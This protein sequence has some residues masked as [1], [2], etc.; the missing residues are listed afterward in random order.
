MNNR[1]QNF[2]YHPIILMRTIQLLLIVFVCF[3]TACDKSQEKVITLPFVADDLEIMLWAESPMLYNPTN[4]DVDSRGRVWITEAV[5]YRNYNN[6]SATHLHHR[7]GD[8]VL[9]LE[10]TDQDGR[11]DKSKVFVQDKDLVSPLGIAVIGNKVY[12][13]CSPNLIVYTDE[14]HDDIPDKK[15]ILL[16]G[17]G[18]KDHD[19]S[20]HAIVGGPDGRLYFNCGNA[21]PHHVTD[22]AGWN[23]RSGSVYTGGSPYN[24]SNSPQQSDD[25]KV[26]IGGLALRMNPDGTGLSIMAHNF[27]NSYEIAVDSR[28]DIWQND[29]DDQVVACR[30]TWVMEGGNAGFFSN[31]GTRY[32]QADQRPGQD[33]FAAHWHQEDPGVM[34][35]GDRSGAGAPTGIVVY[36]GNALGEKYNGMLLSADAGRNVVFAYHPHI[37]RS[38]YNLNKRINF[39]TSLAEDNTGYV[40]DD[41]L[42]NSDSTKWFRPSDVAV[43]I[44]GAIFVADWYDPVVGGHQMEDSAGFGR[45]YRIVPKGKKLKM[46]DL[47]LSSTEG[48][49]EALLNPAVNVRHE[50]FMQ[51]SKKGDAIVPKLMPLL[52]EDNEFIRSRAIWLLAATGPNGKNEVQ[53]LLHDPDP[54]VRRVAFRALRANSDSILDYGNDIANDSSAFVR[55]ELIAAIMNEPYETVKPLLTKLMSKFDAD[56]RWYL[57][58]LGAAVSGHESDFMTEVEKYWNKDNQSPAH[59]GKEME[60]LAWRLHPKNYAA[61]FK[62]RALSK[63]LDRKQ[64]ERAITALGFINDRDAVKAMLSLAAGGDEAVREIASYWI[65]FRQSNDWFALADWTRLNINPEEQRKISVMKVK[66]SKIMDDVLPENEKKWNLSDMAR[67][68]TG[69]RMV[70]GAI[71]EGNFPPRLLDEAKD[72]LLKNE[73]EQ[74]KLQ[75][76]SL[77]T[78]SLSNSTAY[79]FENIRNL[80]SSVVKGKQ[81]F[82][83]YCAACH[84]VGTAGKNI[85][86]ELTGIGGKYDRERLIQAITDPSA[87]IVFGYETWTINTSNGMSYYGFI[88]GE[89]SDAV[90]VKDLS[91]TK[92]TIPLKNIKSRKKTEKS[93]MPDATAFGLDEQ[94]LADLSAYL[95]TLQ[96]Q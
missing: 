24:T 65:G 30:T 89:G 16:T 81:L 66:L 58:S 60:A 45:I 67:D 83:Q 82:Q 70:L 63:D 29:N 51:L 64:R 47:D 78:D 35:A 17:F 19:H 77:F 54:S 37:E 18:G 15:E 88:L 96:N 14:N 32:W 52:R 34:P 31:D 2:N 94:G 90:I 42:Q 41:S 39:L 21:G 44:D 74:I 7:A 6:D 68:E 50:A 56:D 79:S 57:E 84:R 80:K 69:A 5:N 72:L 13:S 43:G 92:H 33:V 20:L 28:G 73:N 27:R 55:R 9:I 46:P 38:G 23:L 26:W 85:G 93:I 4:M 11:A 75:A 53:K 25:G 10:D 59:W 8:R 95:Q 1:S 61:A 87:G 22:K 71:A 48:Q 49:I 3:L 36:E 62:E 76:T 12:V 86:P 91:G 40:W